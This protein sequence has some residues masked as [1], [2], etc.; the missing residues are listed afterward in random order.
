MQ[1]LVV[2]K[3]TK[4][5]SFVSRVLSPTNIH[6]KHVPDGFICSFSLTIYL[7]MINHVEFNSSSSHLEECGLKFTQKLK[8][9]IVDDL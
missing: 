9:M 2:R 6:F 7:R 5:Q 8:I 1:S 3:F 4:I